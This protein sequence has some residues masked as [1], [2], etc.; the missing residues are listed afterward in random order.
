VTGSQLAEE[1]I[2]RHG[3]DRYPTPELQALK[4]CAEMG[5][6]ASEILR[7][8]DD[9]SQ[10]ISYAQLSKIRKELG[11]VGLTLHALATKLGMNVETAMAD[12]VSGEFRRFA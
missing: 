10:E 3:R 5:E 2:R 9:P 7:S 4:L 8:R 1:Q 12:V 6:L 11:D